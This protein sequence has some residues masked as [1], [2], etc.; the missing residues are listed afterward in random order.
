MSAFINMA[1]FHANIFSVKQLSFPFS[2]SGDCWGARKHICIAPKPHQPLNMPQELLHIVGK[3][4]Q[5]LQESPFIFRFLRLEYISSCV[6]L[7]I[8]LSECT[9]S[10]TDSN[11]SAEG[12]DS[13]V[14]SHTTAKEDNFFNKGNMHLK[15]RL[16]R[17]AS[18][19]HM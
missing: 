12:M 13:W 5:A 17:A 10:G 15:S 2:Y 11:W 3:T 9:E 6:A 8:K 4:C 19:L 7:L 1:P 18:R 16:K 14:S